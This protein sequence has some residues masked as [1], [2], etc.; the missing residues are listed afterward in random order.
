[1]G[2]AETTRKM[3]SRG[4]ERVPGLR[5]GKKFNLGKMDASD[6]D[7]SELKCGMPL[8]DGCC[9]AWGSSGD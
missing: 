8:S 9:G 3:M 4:K 2:A 6:R 1:M 7:R 5:G